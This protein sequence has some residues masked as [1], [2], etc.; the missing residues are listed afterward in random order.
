MN[1][2]SYLNKYFFFFPYNKYF[3]ADINERKKWDINQ[4]SKGYKKKV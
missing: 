4:F 2:Q 1:D 3:S